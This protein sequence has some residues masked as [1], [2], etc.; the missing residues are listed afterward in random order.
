MERIHAS[1][2]ELIDLVLKH[3]GISGRM[4]SLYGDV[5]LNY[6][7]LSE[8]KKEFILK[9]KY[10]TAEK[11]NL[12]FQH[13][14][15][16]HLSASGLEMPT[17]LVALGGSTVIACK[18]GANDYL[19]SMLTWMPGR[20]WSEQ[21]PHTTK[22]LI[23]LGKMLGRISTALAGFTHSDAYRETLWDSARAEW[24]DTKLI[25]FEG[26]Q[27]QLVQYFLNQY[28]S[29]DKLRAALRR[30][31]IH[32]DANDNNIILN[33]DSC[34]TTVRSVIDYGDALYTYT[35]CELAN[36]LAYLMMDKRNPVHSAL[37]VIRSYHDQF[38]LQE[39]EVALLPLMIAMRLMIS[40]THSTLNYQKDPT[41]EYHQISARGAWQLLDWLRSA[42]EQLMIAQFRSA[43]AWDPS[44]K[45]ERYHQW[46]STSM[47]N[48][49]PIVS[50]VNPDNTVAL[51]LSVDSTTL[52]HYSNYTDIRKMGRMIEDQRHV[53]KATLGIG[54]YAEVRPIYTN[55]GFMEIGDEGPGWRTVHL[56]LDI[57]GPEGTTVLAPLRGVVHSV[58]D[59]GMNGDYGPTVILKHNEEE[60]EFYTLYGH[61]SNTDLDLLA[62]G[63]EVRA[64]EIIGHFGAPDENGDWPPHVHFQI[65]LDLF[66]YGHNY[67]GVCYYD[68]QVFWKTICP[69]PSG[70]LGIGKNFRPEEAVS[71]V[72]LVSKRKLLLGRSL[73]V[74][75][76]RPLHMVRG[77]GQYLMD[78]TGRRYLDMVNNVAHVG[79]EH[80]KVVEAGQRQMALLNTNTRYLHEE[81]TAFAE[82]LISTLPSP[83]SVCHFANS[84]SEANELALRMA[85]V[86]TGAKDIIA[87]AHGYH[88]NTQE[89][90]N[91]SS[92]KFDSPGGEGKPDHVHLLD[93]PDVY[94]GQFRDQD[95]GEHYASQA[96]DLVATL[97]KNGKKP[98]AL[99][100]ESILSCGGQVML[101][102]DYLSYIYNKVRAAGGVCIADEVQ[103]GIGRIGEH[104][105]GFELSGVVPDIVTIGKPL[106]NGHPVAAVITTPEIA[107]A[108]DNGMEFFNTFGGNPVS[109]AIGRSVLKVVEEEDLQ[110]HALEMG[111]R[112]KNGLLE[113]QTHYPIIG[114]VRGVGLFQG[115]E[116]VENLETLYPADKQASYLTNRMREKGVLLSTDGPL[117][118]VIKI[119]PPMVIQAE[120][121]DMALSLLDE[122][123]QETQMKI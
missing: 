89:C 57:F 112:L 47:A 44:G 40:V 86:Y 75:Y 58:Y 12:L 106:G 100:C 29:S 11:E 94:R 4:R 120:D 17:P 107:D 13:K 110:R 54:R 113:L 26:E 1:S 21:V 114:D 99:I 52:G 27:K 83:L 35:I 20:L 51:D 82:E 90:I 80:P 43:C 108:F 32:G 87:V 66:E 5:D 123:F 67:P 96:K 16:H 79:H 55:D 92:Y 65:I 84:G 88:G 101:P 28:L 53:Q 122:V 36:A 56:G 48:L 115:F 103:V 8:N 118:N 70:W 22:M 19:M 25:V 24:I 116:L 85:K 41:N 6:H 15:A 18:L 73:S 91:V 119:K 9:L 95:A 34:E 46:F 74:S 117:H 59:N 33:D 62:Q 61:L 98:A 97:I 102:K 7:V 69:D 104:Y 3:Y 2:K 39:N 105:W 38:P 14:M 64:G 50:G 109:C 31:V 10:G 77:I 60:L 72:P 81:L 37:P 68:E 23:S 121:I 42:D 63:R 30:S 45:Y 93:M 78:H 76:Q 49:R 71:P 111:E